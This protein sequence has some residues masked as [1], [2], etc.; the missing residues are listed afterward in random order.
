MGKR[1]AI[2]DME[3]QSKQKMGQSLYSTIVFKNK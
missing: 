2:I 3:L 1:T